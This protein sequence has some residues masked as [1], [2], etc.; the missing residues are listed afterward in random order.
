MI[1]PTSNVGVVHAVAGA[2][3]ARSSVGLGLSASG[4]GPNWDW[5]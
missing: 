3:G 1:Q 4:T 2:I 5:A